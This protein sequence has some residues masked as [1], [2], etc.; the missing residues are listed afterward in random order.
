MNRLACSPALALLSVSVVVADSNDNI[1][2]TAPVPEPASI[3]LMGEGLAA[4]AYAG[5]RRNRKS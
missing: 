2:P 5:W 1:A 3:V 4:V